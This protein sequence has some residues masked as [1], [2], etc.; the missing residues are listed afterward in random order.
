MDKATNVRRPGSKTPGEG[1][2]SAVMTPPDETGVTGM[3]S[4]SGRMPGEGMQAGTIGAP[5]V[6]GRMPDVGMLGAAIEA[7][8][9]EMPGEEMQGAPIEAPSAAN[10]MPGERMQHTAMGAPSATGKMPAEG[11]HGVPMP[12]AT[13]K[14][15]SRRTVAAEKTVPQPHVL[16]KPGESLAAAALVGLGPYTKR[17][18]TANFDVYYDNSLGATG[19]NLADAVL[20]NC[21]WDL[22]E[23]RGWFGGVAAGRFSVYIDPGSF[24]LD[25]SFN[26]FLFL[27]ERSHLMLLL[28]LGDNR[29][30]FG[31]VV[32]KP[33][34]PTIRPQNPRRGCFCASADRRATVRPVPDL[35]GIAPKGRQWAS[36]PPCAKR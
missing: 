16:V 19:Q 21:E 4:A 22:F 32:A 27:L 6:I 30:D 24:G 23:L 35:S 36:V 1:M 20:A 5:S 8:S 3:P 14:M 12:S 31:I 7:S 15:P 17:G 13:A 25:S 9:G 33:A 18:S 11:T 2:P 10:K 28:K 34:I 29:L 26:P